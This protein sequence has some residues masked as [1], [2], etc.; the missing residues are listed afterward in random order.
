MKCL[1]RL[2]KENG[3]TVSG[4]FE[5]EG[6]VEEAFEFLDTLSLSTGYRQVYGEVRGD[7]GTAWVRWISR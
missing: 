3:P 7:E 6:G 1:V 2:F 5:F 4:P